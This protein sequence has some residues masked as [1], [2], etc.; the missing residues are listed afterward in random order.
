M[1]PRTALACPYCHSPVPLGLFDFNPTQKIIFCRSCFRGSRLPWPSR[2]WGLCTLLL[3][4]AAELAFLKDSGVWMPDDLVGIALKAAL[5]LGV[6]LSSSL[7]ASLVSRMLATSLVGLTGYAARVADSP[8]SPPAPPPLVLL[9]V[10]GLNHL[11]YIGTLTA[12]LASGER[13]SA[14]ERYS[15]PHVLAYKGIYSKVSPEVHFWIRLHG[16]VTAALVILTLAVLLYDAMRR[17]T[18]RADSPP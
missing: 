2:V 5:F 14:L 1:N 9:L 18:S 16:G 3:V 17:P 8:A 15:S 6:V 11:L 4:M 13:V 12:A 10:T 7:V